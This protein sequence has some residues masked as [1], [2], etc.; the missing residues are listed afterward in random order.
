MLKQ[1]WAVGAVVAE[2][3]FDKKISLL[4]SLDNQKTK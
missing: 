2:T 3:R 4:S 1:C